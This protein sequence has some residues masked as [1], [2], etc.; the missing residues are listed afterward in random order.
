MNHTDKEAIV[1][2]TVYRR[3]LMPSKKHIF[4]GSLLNFILMIGIAYGAVLW[5]V[6]FDNFNPGAPIGV[7]LV[8]VVGYY[9]LGHWIFVRFKWGSFGYF[10]TRIIYIDAE[11][12]QRLDRYDIYHLWIK[13]FL[14]NFKYVDFYEMFYF[15]N[16]Y[17]N[18]TIAMY[19]ENVYYVKYGAYK[20]MVKK[21]DLVVKDRPSV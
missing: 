5:L 7:T 20:K 2:K 21:G 19:N 10:L 6:D 9:V 16:S 3:R 15:F 8:I 14:N 13:G 17:Y 18:Q 1:N 12:G 11:T 4:L